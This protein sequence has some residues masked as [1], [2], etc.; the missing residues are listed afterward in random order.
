VDAAVER[1]GLSR[2]RLLAQIVEDWLE[3]QEE[4]AWVA[5]YGKR[6]LTNQ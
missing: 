5:R 1:L 2:A 3:D 4:A 6:V